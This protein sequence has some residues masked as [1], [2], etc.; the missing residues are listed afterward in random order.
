V[1]GLIEKAKWWKE[2]ADRGLTATAKQGL[3][4][5]ALSAVAPST[6]RAYATAFGAFDK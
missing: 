2:A 5:G 3:V 1:A 6:L 4:T